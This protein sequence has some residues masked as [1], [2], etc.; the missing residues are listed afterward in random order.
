MQHFDLDELAAVVAIANRESFSAAARDLNKTQ[1]AV[2]LVVGRLE[3]RLSHK[4]FERSPRG[5]RPTVPGE[6]L[7]SYARR[8]LA[9]ESEALE[10]LNG[11]APRGRVRIGMPDDYLEALGT[12]A[13]EQ[14]ALAC[15]GVQV[16]IICDFSRKLETLVGS[17]DLDLAIVTRGAT[18]Q[19]GLTLGRERQVWCAAPSARP[20]LLKPLPLALFSDQ[21]RAKPTILNALEAAG[22]SYRIA[23]SFS[24]L[25]GILTAV[26]KG[27][28]VTVLPESCVPAHFRKL[29]I[30]SG[31]PALPTLELALLLPEGAKAPARIL[32]QLLLPHDKAPVGPL[33][34]AN[35]A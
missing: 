8:L 31:L 27:R 26:E 7:I 35:A 2:S 6:T 1:A 11:A 18:Q 12:P 16:D 5:V 23:Y 15:P 13:I 24:H 29:G 34:A 10:A 33:T 17:G 3:Q 4:L 21:C 28:A 30:E 25:A 9:L 14:F 19:G 32:G 20:E 22:R